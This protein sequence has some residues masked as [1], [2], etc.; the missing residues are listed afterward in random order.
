MKKKTSRGDHFSGQH[1]PA[2][3]TPRSSSVAARPAQPTHHRDRDRAYRRAARDRSEKVRN[4]A[5]QRSSDVAKDPCCLLS[6][7]VR[8]Y[9]DSLSDPSADLGARVP[10]HV[11]NRATRR[12]MP[13]RTGG[14]IT[15]EVATNTTTQV[16]LF[17]G[18][19]GNSLGGTSA[20]PT[21][22]V[23]DIVQIA[24]A[25]HMTPG[26]APLGSASAGLGIATS[27]IPAG[28]FSH[29]SLLATAHLPWG[30]D[31]PLTPVS[32]DSSILRWRLVS[33]SITVHNTTE[34][35]LRGGYIV[36]VSPSSA[37][38]PSY[39]GQEDFATDPTYQ[40]WGTQIDNGRC[41]CPQ[42][43]HDGTVALNGGDHD[44]TCKSQ[45]LCFKPRGEDIPFKCMSNAT[46][47][48]VNDQAAM[49][50]FLNGAALASQYYQIS[51]VANWEIAG[52][53]VRGMTTPAINDPA[54]AEY[55]A[56]ALSQLHDTGLPTADVQNLALVAKASSDFGFNQVLQS[57]MGLIDSAR[58]IAT[59]VDKVVSS[60]FEED[61]AKVVLEFLGASV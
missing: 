55:L 9:T 10:Y 24:G 48:T 56:P 59:S 26:P 46:D 15:F 18:Y 14:Q 5:E 34:A 44:A 28:G 43:E 20:Q 19:A 50:I 39:T 60:V 7:D 6:P 11:N 23:G 53:A 51:Y 12:S 3:G 42:S 37:I 61:T 27:A 52:S 35:E 32:S 47:V 17:S 38:N 21:G 40:L 57:G 29:S 8:L 1:P 13:F 49:L 36:S 2:G 54:A 33:M 22:W 4:P 30:F 41:N 16:T 58:T 45:E 31:F 25:T